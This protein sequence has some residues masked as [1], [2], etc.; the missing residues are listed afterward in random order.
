MVTPAPR[1]RRRGRRAAW[2]PLAYAVLGLLAAL[3]GARPTG[4][5]WLDP[6]LL[7]L[8][9]A[10]LAAC[11][12]RARTVPLYLAAASVAVLQPEPAPLALAVV[13]LVAA[14][15]RRWDR[16]SSLAGALAGGL[17]WAGAVG[18][19]SEPGASP[20]W[21]PVL[22]FGWVAWSAHRYGS[23]RFRQRFELV[24]G[25]VGG[26]L[27]VCAG[28][29]A[30]AAVNARSSADR[31]ADLLRSGLD[32]AR[33]G[34][35]EEAVADLRAARRA[36]GRA[37]SSLG[38]T[39][40]RPAWLVPGVS[41]NLRTLH[42]LTEEVDALA[43]QA[44]ATV[45]AANLGELRARG[46][47]IDLAAVSAVEEPLLELRS[48]LEVG[49][50]EVSAL[51]GH[52][53]LPPVQSGLDDVLDELTETIP[54]TD[55][56]IEGVRVAPALLGADEPATYLVLFT[57]PVEARAT[58][59]FPGN[60]AEVTFT[61]GAFDMTRFGRISELVAA[62]PEGGGTLSGPADYLARYSAYK[63]NWEWRN[64]TMSPDLPSVAQ[65]VG[66]LYP[67]SGGRPIDGVMTVDP[68]AL[69]A[70]LRFTGPVAVPGLAEPLDHENAAE[71]LLRE[72]YLTFDENPDRIDALETIAEVTFDRLGQRDLPGIAGLRGT[73][74][75][76]VERKHLQ[77]WAFDPAAGPLLDE[78]GLSGRYPAVEGDF[79][80]V[81]HTNASGN[82][83]DLFFERSL[84]YQVMWDPSTGALSATATIT[85]TNTAPTTG[86]PDYVIG[87]SL[88]NH[89][90]DEAPPAGW[91]KVFLTLYTPW[92]VAAATLDG[93][94]VALA[95]STELSRT[96][97]S[98][99]V[100]LA[101][102]QTRT[103]VVELEGALAGPQYVLD[104]GAQPM[105]T[106]E[107]ASVG[108]R[109]AG[110]WDLSATGPVEVSGSEI[111]GSFP[112]VSDERITTQRR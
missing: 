98:A 112:L 10:A 11:G 38:A 82:K 102:G 65:V 50:A 6:V 107:E 63:P 83:I 66:E 99:F 21:V 105:V 43:G 3:G 31:G 70:L 42:R 74:G 52:W 76:V 32:A 1:A 23:R 30:V 49:L 13:A 110:D 72:Q 87:N 44:V 48:A 69:A 20:L 95:G 16:R 60:F 71:F 34:D 73:L 106:P 58:G 75:P 103:V 33:I 62:L 27:V 9:G 109:I 61:D 2:L 37:E 94:P 12:V 51:R 5:G 25:V 84:D 81:T 8:G 54:S 104:L 80:G 29:G 41:Q 26:V 24:G 111:S 78:L 92:D 55:L 19:P 14:F 15:A 28:L 39:W 46:G 56:A 108:V 89:L 100:D 4:L 35:T 97:L 88:E 40:A 18:V 86:L 17:A 53:L 68:V 67:Q 85:M 77:V 79:V 36:I 7:G 47:R 93:E 91:H 57:T 101:P 45:E 59:G 64:I 90:G 96:A 22:A